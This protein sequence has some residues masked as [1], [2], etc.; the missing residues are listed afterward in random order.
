MCI[1]RL[2]HLS[3]IAL[4]VT[5]SLCANAQDG[6][7]DSAAAKTAACLEIENA[8]ERLACFET[9]AKGLN[10][11]LNH[12]E[13][14]SDQASDAIASSEAAPAPRQNAEAPAADTHVAESPA[15][16]AEVASTSQSPAGQTQDKPSDDVPIWARVFNDDEEASDNEIKV[17]V[18]RILRNNFGRHYFITADGQEWRQ[19]SIEDVDPPSGL[20]VEATI[21]KN[22]LGAP[23][24]RFNDGTQGSYRVRREK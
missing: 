8:V 18:V 4:P 3:L 22:M 13:Q 6:D 15:S 1:V 5:F 17:S 20:P 14:P 21:E 12:S 10:D 11:A 19:T 2:R 16:A 24:L 9:T 23:S 7:L